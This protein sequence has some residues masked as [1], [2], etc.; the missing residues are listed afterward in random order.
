V[1]IVLNIVKSIHIINL[2]YNLK[3]VYKILILQF[4]KYQLFKDLLYLRTQ[5]FI[6]GTG[7]MLII[8]FGVLELTTGIKIL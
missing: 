2:E 5:K 8:N 3:L 4:I 6:N 1:Q 7:I